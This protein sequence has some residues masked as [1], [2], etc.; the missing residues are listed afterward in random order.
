MTN[1]LTAP[2]WAAAADGRLT[3]QQCTECGNVQWTPQA[4]CVRCL[5]ERLEWRTCSGDGVLYSSSVV[6]R[7]PDPAAHPAPYTVA[8]VTLAEGPSLLTRL[9]PCAPEL[10]RAGSPVHVVFTEHDGRMLY[11][12]EV[13]A[14]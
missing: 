2:F 11:E 4:A 5:G 7:S 10:V 13:Q 14:S 8:V 9:R 3:V 12:F 6:H 1:P